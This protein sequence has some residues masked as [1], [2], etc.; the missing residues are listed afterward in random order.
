MA[1]RQAAEAKFAAESEP[2]A[3]A[4]DEEDDEEEDGG[5]VELEDRI[6]LDVK[7]AV[8]LVLGARVDDVA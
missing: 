8:E 7:A 5:E 4:A 6:V 3:A 2:E 1:G